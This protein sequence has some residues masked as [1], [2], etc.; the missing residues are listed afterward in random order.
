MD[1]ASKFELH[2]Y[3]DNNS[4]A[5]DAIVKNKC[6]A[7]IIAVAYEAISIIGL[8]LSIDVEAIQQGGI[9]D[10]WRVLGENNAQIALIIYVIA[11]LLS[12]A[13]N[14]DTEF[15]ELKKEDVKL[16]IEERKLRIEKLNNELK[17]GEVTTETL[18][19]SVDIINQNYKVRSEERRVG[20]EC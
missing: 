5:M 6:E 16:S 17:D 11:I 1:I 14:I 13:P 19:S 7:E 9:K 20:K 18:E 12:Q 8:D 2:Y 3:L 10:V 15:E 4:H